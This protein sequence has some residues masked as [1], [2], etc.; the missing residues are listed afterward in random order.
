M[1]KL[2]LYCSGIALWVNGKGK[3]RVTVK[4][5]VELDHFLRDYSICVNLYW[6]IL[7]ARPTGLR[8][9]AVFLVVFFRSDVFIFCLSGVITKSYL[10]TN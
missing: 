4:N 5:I 1:A 2:Y 3:K 9:Y 8:V 6:L 10:S 7:I